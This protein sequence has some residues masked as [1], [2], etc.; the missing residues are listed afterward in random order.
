MFGGVRAAVALRATLAELGTPA[1]PIE[2]PSPHIA[3]ALDE[4]RKPQNEHVPRTLNRFLDEF[5]WY[6]R[7]LQRQR[8]EGTP[9]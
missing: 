5:E 4:D 3:T 1:I 6:A 8:R 2:Y 7:A 9:Y